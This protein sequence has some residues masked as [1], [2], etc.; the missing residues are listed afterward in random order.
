MALS[1]FQKSFMTS[2]K[3]GSRD[4]HIAPRAQDA[5]LSDWAPGRWGS[6][7][8]REEKRGNR[9][10][11]VKGIIELL[12]NICSCPLRWNTHSFEGLT[13]GESRKY[14]FYVQIQLAKVSIHNQ[15]LLWWVGQ[16]YNIMTFSRIYVLWGQ[17]KGSLFFSGFRDD[18]CI[19][20]NESDVSDEGID[21]R[22]WL[23]LVCIQQLNILFSQNESRTSKLCLLV[24]SSWM[25]KQAS[26][27]FVVLLILLDPE[28]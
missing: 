25:V 18:F 28:W 8:V 22:D 4:W 23:E 7:R 26:W 6:G 15:T 11:K 5:N 21:D 24:L 1:T 16:I 3:N 12:W 14:I 17:W 13:K 19:C 10:L 27:F 2:V 9:E 20:Q